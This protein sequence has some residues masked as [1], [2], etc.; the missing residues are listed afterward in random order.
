LTAS[1]EGPSTNSQHAPWNVPATM[2]PSQQL[3][4]PSA[5]RPV[6]HN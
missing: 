5:S 2:A 1:K 4:S 3:P 6:S